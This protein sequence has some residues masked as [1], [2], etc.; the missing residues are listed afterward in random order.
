[1]PATP[2]A[3]AEIYSPAERR[4]SYTGSLQAARVLHTATPLND[5]RVLVTGGEQNGTGSL[6]TAEIYTPSTGRFT[7]T[8]AMADRRQAHTAT[9]LIDGRVLIVG[10]YDGVTRTALASTEIYDPVLDVFT[11]GRPL[12][13]ARQLHSA[14]LLSNGMVLIAGGMS[15]TGVTV[16]AE[17]YDPGTGQFIVT[18]DLQRARL[19]HQATLLADGRVL[20]TGGAGATVN[21]DSVAE[22]EIY[23]PATREFTL[24]G[25][26]NQPR[27][28]HTATLLD[29]GEVLIAG[30]SPAYQSTVATDMIEL[31]IPAT[32]RLI[33][34][35]FAQIPR[36]RHT[37]HAARHRRRAAHR[38]P[39]PEPHPGRRAGRLHQ[40]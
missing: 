37:A 6:A 13:V 28:G 19:L 8:R 39:Q 16:R 20:I 7:Y 1:M 29:T 40:L 31:F 14:T 34:A 2:R 18:D 30:G 22:V 15:N 38:R 4:F 27:Q 23:A 11:P 3:N 36:E 9:R 24:I 25:S 17:L 12:S 33:V 10:G 5:G 32:E 26:L 21:F 35:G